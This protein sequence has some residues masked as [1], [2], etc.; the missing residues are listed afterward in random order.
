[1]SEI[2]TGSNV[3]IDNLN[4]SKAKIKV[5]GKSWQA[6]RSG[7][8]KIKG[9]STDI[10]DSD[11]WYVVDTSSAFQPLEDGWGKFEY[12]NTDGTANKFINAKVKLSAMKLKENTLYSF[13][14]E[15][16]NS[17]IS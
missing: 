4:N 10:D 12:D 7:K 11:Y 15:I 17:S 5:N 1:M 6:T 13:I 16:R 9:F 3:I 14:A 2:Y 8:N